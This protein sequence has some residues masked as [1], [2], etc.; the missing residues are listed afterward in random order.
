MNIL[1]PLQFSAASTVLTGITGTA[2]TDLLTKTA[3]GLSTGDPFI[4]TFS[5]GFT[6]LTSGR[7][8][9]AIKISADTFKA[10]ATLALALA[11]TAIDITA[12]GTSASVAIATPLATSPCYITSG[13]VAAR[14]EGNAFPAYV[15]FKNSNGNPDPRTPVTLSMPF[16]FRYFG[17]DLGQLYVLAAAGDGVDCL[18]FQ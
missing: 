14:V 17:Y 6:G 8:Y 18:G 3:H 16:T 12:D 1:K 9:Y 15:G 4:P 10:A 2:S 5:T 13:Q 11:G 7:R